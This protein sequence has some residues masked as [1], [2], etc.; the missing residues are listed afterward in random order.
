[1]K[2]LTL[3]LSL[4]LIISK[5]YTQTRIH[6]PG[7]N[8][9][10]WITYN[11]D[12]KINEK[13]GI[14]FDGHIRRS[15][16]L[17]KGQQLLFRPGIN[18]HLNNAVS[19]GIGYAYA[20]T[21]A[22]GVFPSPAAFPENRLWE[23]VQV[24]TQL[25]KIEWVS[26]LR[27]EH[28][29]INLPVKNAQGIY[30]PGKAA[31]INRYRLMNRIAIPLKGKTI[32]EGTTYI[33]AMDEVMINSGKYAA[34]NLLDQ[35]RAYIALGHFVPKLGKVELGYMMQSIVKT[36]GIRIEKNN[37]IQLTLNSTANFYKKKKSGV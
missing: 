10:V 14:H 27:L 29:F 2:K 15:D 34:M 6:R 19:F 35:N 3:I 31:F 24:K 5:T 28:R 26:R 11:G 22:Y 1:M 23:Q 37:T 36:D 13:W 32:K 8:N 21:Y 12:H 4:L 9:N 16:F 33:T 20:Y 7:T 18:Y 30:E 25:Q 17:S